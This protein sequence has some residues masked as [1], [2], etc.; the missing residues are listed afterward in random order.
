MQYHTEKY[1]L[2]NVYDRYVEDSW[3]ISSIKKINWLQV[4][5]IKC[6]WTL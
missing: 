3:G 6:D 1:S 2:S 5:V 4:S